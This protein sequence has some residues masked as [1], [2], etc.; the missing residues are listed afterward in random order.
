SRSPPTPFAQPSEAS[1]A[2]ADQRRLCQPW[3]VTK[4][5]ICVVGLGLIRGSVMRAAAAAGRDVF[6]YN[7]SVDV[8]QAARFD[9]FDVTDNLDEALARAADS[10]ALIV[11]A[12]PMPA[13]P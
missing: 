10:T 6:G 11:L 5:P 8:I 9:G 2:S 3:T 4:T 7:R 1:P 13:L 12:V